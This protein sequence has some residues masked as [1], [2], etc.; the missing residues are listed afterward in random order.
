MIANGRG[1]GRANR[2]G[3]ARAIQRWRVIALSSGERTLSAM[4]A[5]IGRKVNAGQSVR[6]LNIPATDFKYGAFE[7]L[8]DFPSGQGFSE[9]LK[10]ARHKDHG[11]VGPAFIE[12]LIKEERSLHERL[13]TLAAELSAEAKTE[14]EGRAASIM[15]LFALAGELGIEYGLLP[16]SQGAARQAI[17]ETFLLWRERQGGQGNEDAQILQSVQD[18]LDRHGDSRFQPRNHDPTESPV[19]RDRAGWYEWDGD[20]RSYMFHSSG[21]KEAGGGFDV[22]RVARALM[23]AGWI[24]DHYEGRFTKSVRINGKLEQSLYAV[25]PIGAE[26]TENKPVTARAAA[27]YSPFT[28]DVYDIWGSPLLWL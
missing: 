5:E 3:R 4:M 15:A 10:E 20:G 11:H 8:H 12:G 22:K 19:I 25:K 2:I 14:L 1:K 27:V 7:C 18:F 16:W 17:H 23:K 9:H 6:L 26:N 21:L 13:K 24:V 28:E